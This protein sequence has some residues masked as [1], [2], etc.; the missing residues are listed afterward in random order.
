MAREGLDATVAAL[1]RLVPTL[2]VQSAGVEADEGST[3]SAERGVATGVPAD[4]GGE[5]RQKEARVKPASGVL[6]V[7]AE[8]VGNNLI[9]LT[10]VG[11]FVAGVGGF[12]YLGIMIRLA[13][14]WSE[15]M[16][17]GM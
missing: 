10:V 15:G 17:A 7:T 2:E 1:E 4:E 11:S 5:A 9:R 8:D 6:E 3:R 13:E 14:L 12:A 16:N